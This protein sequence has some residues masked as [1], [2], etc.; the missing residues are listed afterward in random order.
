[1]ACLSFGKKYR[2]IKLTKFLNTCATEGDQIGNDFP[3]MELFSKKISL[4][5]QFKEVSQLEIA[6]LIISQPHF[7]RKSCTFKKIPETLEDS[8]I[9]KICYNDD[10]AAYRLLMIKSKFSS[11][12]TTVLY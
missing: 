9:S 10:E 4:S 12:E 3:E 7:L 5:K 11:A 1:L 8:E 6:K 2:L